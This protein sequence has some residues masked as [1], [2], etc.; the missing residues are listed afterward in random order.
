LTDVFADGRM[1]FRFNTG[2]DTNAFGL[3]CQSRNQGTH[4]SGYTSY[5]YAHH[6]VPPLQKRN[7]SRFFSLSKFS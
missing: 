5:C 7:A 6:V 2:D 3:K 1:T 4:P